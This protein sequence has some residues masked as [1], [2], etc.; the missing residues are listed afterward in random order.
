MKQGIE[1]M[2][3]YLVDYMA[4]VD[5]IQLG[6]AFEYR[7]AQLECWSDFALLQYWLTYNGVFDGG[8]SMLTELKRLVAH[9]PT[10][11][12]KSVIDNCSI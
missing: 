8:E 5:S 3:A 10:C 2:R 9:S 6:G 11:N 7:K 1:N 4:E 12:P